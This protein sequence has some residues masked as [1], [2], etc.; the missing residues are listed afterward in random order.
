MIQIFLCGGAESITR[1]WWPLLA[2]SRERSMQDGLARH[3]ITGHSARLTALNYGK[4]RLLFLIK[5]LFDRV[6]IST[7]EKRQEHLRNMAKMI[8]NRCESRQWNKLPQ[9]G[10]V[11]LCLFLFVL[12]VMLFLYCIVSYYVM[13]DLSS[14]IRYH[15]MLYFIIFSPM[16]SF[17][18]IW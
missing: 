1:W 5:F 7:V 9:P 11:T 13:I 3:L 18:P 15:C 12:Y 14:A 8:W 4:G 6:M 10:H 17:T 2:S 16:I